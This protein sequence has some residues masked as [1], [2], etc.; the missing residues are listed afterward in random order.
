MDATV[1]AVRLATAYRSRGRGQVVVDGLVRLSAGA[2]AETWRFVLVDPSGMSMPMIVQRFA[3]DRQFAAALDKRTQGLVQRHAHDAGIC[4]PRVDLVFEPQDGLGEG[5]VSAWVAGETLGQRIARHV[6][7]AAARR[8]LTAQCAQALAAIHHLDTTGLPPLPDESPAVMHANLRDTHDS[9]GVRLPVFE[10]AFR[11]L[12][13][14][15]PTDTGR[16]LVH[17]DFR[18]GNLIVDP[19][20][21]L[22]AVLDWEAAHLGDPVEDLAWMCVNAWRFGRIEQPV[23]GFGTREALCSAYAAAGGGTVDRARLRY[24]EVWGTLKWGVI[25]QWFGHQFITGEVASLERAAIGRRVS[26][27]ELDLLDLIEGIE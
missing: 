8:L 27:T 26:E 25:C 20:H 16:R 6:D 13:E 12:K 7:F 10:L 24:W 23:G 19:V 5:F 1:L 14:H 9:F 11:W 21:G 2:S 17:G 4:T 18:N 22:V 3:G 15:M